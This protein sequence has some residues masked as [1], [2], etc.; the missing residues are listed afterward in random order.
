MARGAV[1]QR[2]LGSSS[3]HC[4]TSGRLAAK[5]AADASKRGDAVQCASATRKCST[6]LDVNN[7]LR[8]SMNTDSPVRDRRMSR[9][10][11]EHTP[12]RVKAAGR[13]HTG[14][15]SNKYTDL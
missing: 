11:N 9:P 4:V 14:A 15:G 6:V 10:S 8:K 13:C 3:C 12:I 7:F 1:P 2:L 5:A